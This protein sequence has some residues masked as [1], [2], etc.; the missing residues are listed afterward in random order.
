M[1]DLTKIS[2]LEKEIEGY[3]VDLKTATSPEEKT[4]YIGLI[5]A[6]TDNLNELLKQQTELNKG[7]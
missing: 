2:D 1:A 7:A 4:M 6:T 3:E 5:Q